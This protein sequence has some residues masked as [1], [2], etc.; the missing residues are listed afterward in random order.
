[1]SVVLG[2]PIAIDASIKPTPPIDAPIPRDRSKTP[3]LPRGPDDPPTPLTRALW[4][5]ESMLPL[6]DIVA[7]EKDG[8]HPRSFARLEQLHQELVDLED[9]T[10]AYFRRE[11][12]DTRFDHLPGC[13]WLRPARATLPQLIS[14]NFMALHR[15][16]IF[17][18][19]Q[20]R[21]EALKACLS[22]L[23]MQRSHFAM[24]QPRQ[25]KT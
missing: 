25:Y 16:Y 13:Q 11:N 23:A 14:F 22:M 1:M 8:P 21:R 17:T 20:S 24:L 15:P 9:R 12:P 4:A 3:V 7:M 10:P 5:F 18:R 19:P 2:R 6:R